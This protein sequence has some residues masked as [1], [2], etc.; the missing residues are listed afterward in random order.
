MKKNPYFYKGVNPTVDLIVVNPHG[1]ILMITRS[2][3]S[4]A[5]PGMLAFP[6]GFIDSDAKDREQWR[7]GLETPEKAAMRELAEE[8][9]L[10]LDESAKLQ[11]VGKYEGNERDPRDNPE[12]WSRSYA[13]IYFIDDEQFQKQKNHIVGLDD[14]EHAQWIELSKL[15]QMKLAFDHNKILEDAMKFF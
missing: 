8:T 3:N 14:A 5:C 12:S 7:P 9:N 2:R 4:E 10:V 1:E 6:G 11:F 15:R 13:F